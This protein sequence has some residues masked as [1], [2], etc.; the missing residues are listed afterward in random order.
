MR[1]FDKKKFYLGIFVVISTIILIVSLYLIGSKKNMF[2]KNFRIS[3]VFT[4]VNGLQP[5]NNVRYAGINVGTVKK[6]SMI[7][8]TTICV[9]MIIEEKMKQHLKK[10]AIATIKTD[11]LVGSMTISI[12]PNIKKSF[13]IAPGDTLQSI[14]KSSTDD[15]L[16]TLGTTNENVAILVNDLLKITKAIN[17]GKGTVATL[18]NDSLMAKDLQKAIYNLHAVSVKANTTMND[19]NEIIASVNYDESLAAVLLSDSIAASQL[20]TIISNL[21]NSSNEINDVIANANDVVIKIKE[22]KGTLDYIVNDTTVVNNIDETIL[23][24]KEGSSLL[25]QELE[26]IKQ[27]VFFKRYFRKLEKQNDENRN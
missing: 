2:G 26:A 15:M 11:G 25:K 4:N 1:N 22:G 9:D 8:D 3:A 10:N 14:K 18:I 12:V 23:N 5:G 7:N 20:K 21:E 6:I 19:V 24:L 13:P 27:S 17:E 16:N